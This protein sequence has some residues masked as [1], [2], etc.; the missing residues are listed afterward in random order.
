MISANPEDKLI[1]LARAG[2]NG[3]KLMDKLNSLME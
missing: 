2:Y 3:L 1:D